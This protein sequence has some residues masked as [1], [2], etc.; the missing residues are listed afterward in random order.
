MEKIDKK[1]LKKGDL[2][3]LKIENL[4]TKG[5]AYG[6]YDENKIY[7]N[8]NAAQNQIVEGIFV[9]RRHKYELIHCKIIDLQGEK[10]RFMM[11]K[12]DKMGDAII[13]TI[14]M[15]SSWKLRQGILRRN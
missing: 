14:L 10:M 12:L 7:T 1:P 5:R 2:I 15:K 13:S 11:I 6:F 8:I 9:K 3:R 4:D